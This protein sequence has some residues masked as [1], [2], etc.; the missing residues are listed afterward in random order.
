MVALAVPAAILGFFG[1]GAPELRP[2]LGASLLSVLL[3]AVGAGG[4]FLAW[5]RDPALDPARALGPVRTVFARAFFVDELYAVVIVRP[6]QAL[7]R[8]VVQFDQRRVDATVLGTGRAAARLGGLVRFVQ[9]GN[10][11]TYLTGLLAGVA[12]I[13]A[14]VV[15]FQ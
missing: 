6:V 8:H 11:Q 13:A 15:I 5:N 1:L 4:A 3:L 14:A 7:A 12:L 10:P 9:N 2:Q